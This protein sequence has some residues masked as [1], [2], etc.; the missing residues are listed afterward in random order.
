M[1]TIEIPEYIRQV[2]LSQSRKAKYLEVGKKLAKKYQ[3]KNK[4]DFRPYGPKL[5]LFNLETGERV[6]ANPKA[7][8]TPRIITINGQKIYNGEIHSHVRNK[9]LS[10]I[11]TSFVP[12]IEKLDPIHASMLPLACILEIHDVVSTPLW[13]VDNRS[14]P[15]VKAFQDV[16][17]GNKDKNGIPRNKVI[18]E[19]DNVLFITQSPAPRFIP[20]E[21]ESERKLVF[22]LS[23][24][25]D[26]RVI[27]NKNYKK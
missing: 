27:N 22:I 16:L 26:P 25:T 5:Y 19:D 14:Y 10:E 12:Y 4:Y 8:G 21:K 24:E 15:Y 2:K 6:I 11:K 20:V 18:L 7:A 1:I 17:T 3:D 23:K 9:I 13:D